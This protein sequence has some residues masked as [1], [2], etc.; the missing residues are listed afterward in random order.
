MTS[1]AQTIS[2]RAAA[3]VRLPMTVSD[4]SRRQTRVNVGAPLRERTRGQIDAS[5]GM[6]KQGEA[7]AVNDLMLSAGSVITVAEASG[8]V[9][10][11]VG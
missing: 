4:S 11:A 8:R 5:A 10:S 6:T 2:N 3:M 7:T 1:Q 9:R